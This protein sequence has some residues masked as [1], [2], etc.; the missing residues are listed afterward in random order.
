MEYLKNAGN[1]Y[2]Q[3]YDDF[4]AYEERCVG[5]DDNQLIAN[6]LHEEEENLTEILKETTTEKTLNLKTNLKKQSLNLMLSL[7]KKTLNLKR[8]LK[9]GRWVEQSRCQSGSKHVSGI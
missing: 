4:H 7:K 1:P 8:N 6:A 5:S 2:Y 3:F 9:M